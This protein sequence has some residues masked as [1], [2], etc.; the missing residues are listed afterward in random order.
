MKA[1]IT[2]HATGSETMFRF[3][4]NLK[5]SALFGMLDQDGMSSRELSGITVKQKTIYLYVLDAECI[6]P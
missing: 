4:R 2:A 3:V 1:T 5:E 6:G